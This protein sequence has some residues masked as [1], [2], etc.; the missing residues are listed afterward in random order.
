MRGMGQS[1]LRGAHPEELRIEVVDPVDDAADRHQPGGVPLLRGDAGGGELLGVEDPHTVHAVAQVRPETVGRVRAGKAQRHADDRDA[2]L[3]RVVPRGGGRGLGREAR[4]CCGGGGQVRG[5]CGGRGVLEEDGLGDGHREPGLQA[6]AEPG[7]EQGVQSQLVEGHVRV[8]GVAEQRADLLAH[9]PGQVVRR[10]A[11]DGPC[12]G[13]AFGEQ[14]AAQ[15]GATHLARRGPREVAGGD[16]QDPGRGQTQ[17]GE[18]LGPDLPRD[19]PV[20]VGAPAHEEQGQPLRTAGFV[21]DAAR[22]DLALADPRDGGGRVLD[23]VAVHVVPVDDDQVLAPAGEHEL[24]LV[25]EGEVT[26]VQP[27]PTRG[28]R[29][30]VGLRVVHVAGGETGGC[31]HLEAAD[32]A[33]LGEPAGVVHDPQRDSPRGRARR[34]EG[35]ALLVRGRLVG[36]HQVAAQTALE[37][38]VHGAGPVQ[39]AVGDGGDRLG[40]PPGRH[41]VAL[42]DPEGGGGVEEAAQHRQHDPLTAA[43][44]CPE[45]AQ[46]P[47]AGRSFGEGVGDQPVREG[48][49]PA[50]PR[51]VGLEEVEPAQ[52]LGQN[53]VGG[54]VDVGAPRED[55]QQVVQ[56]ER[57]AVVDGQP[58]HH[59]VVRPYVQCPACAR[60]ELRQ[61]GVGQARRLGGTGAARGQHQ[62]RDVGPGGLGV[63]LGRIRAQT[64][65]GDGDPQVRGGGRQVPGPGTVGEHQ[66][67]VQRRAGVQQTLVR[68]GAGNG[69]LRDRRRLGAAQETGP[70]GG[71]ELPEG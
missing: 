56:Q 43:E 10:G 16:G 50:V 47:A 27:V 32:P 22:R 13:V 3:G 12:G 38:A 67:G 34:D 36:P 51:L 33:R 8:H 20:L 48:R 7:E 71:E 41:D 66:R 25:E 1:G 45:P 15:L 2:A 44:Q 42:P 14:S 46:V 19:P 54:G 4:R 69:P 31:P 60:G 63:V 17:P 58:V 35:G 5:E 55:R 70:E 65:L 11:G 37:Q 68:G 6:G 21:R 39:P 53:A 18:Q 24:P 26:G 23:L 64:L 9:R 59:R 57:P 49:G 30:R 28:E 62:Q 52:W 29:L 40:H 61:A